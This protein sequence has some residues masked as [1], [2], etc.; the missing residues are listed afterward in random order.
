MATAVA[1]T[2]FPSPLH[3][4]PYRISREVSPIPRNKTAHIVSTVD[5]NAC[6]IRP[7]LP[8]T[9]KI[10]QTSEKAEMPVDID[11]I[12]VY[13]TCNVCVR[14][15]RL[16]SRC[17]TRNTQTKVHGIGWVGMVPLPE[18]IPHSPRLLRTSP[19]FPRVAG[20]FSAGFRFSVTSQYISASSPKRRQ[21]VM[22]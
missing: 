21:I 7:G 15:H 13:N 17:K 9:A 3:Q 5:Q 1:V 11:V 20:S 4:N 12:L 8:E 18:E 14:T 2:I 16:W 19:Y 6:P 10:S 22:P